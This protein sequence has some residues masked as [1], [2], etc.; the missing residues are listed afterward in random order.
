MTEKSNEIIE[1]PLPF[2]RPRTSV[3]DNPS[4]EKS[5]IGVSPKAAVPVVRE[6]VHG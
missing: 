2:P 6:L 1:S 3:S 4:E 5:E